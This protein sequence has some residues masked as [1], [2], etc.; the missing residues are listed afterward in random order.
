MTATITSLQNMA[1]TVFAPL[2]QIN[3][4]DISISAQLG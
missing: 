1:V 4:N 2:W 3:G